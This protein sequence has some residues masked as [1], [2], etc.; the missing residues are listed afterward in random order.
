MHGER[1]ILRYRIRYDIFQMNNAYRNK[2]GSSKTRNE[3]FKGLTKD[4]AI[5][6]VYDIIAAKKTSKVE[7]ADS[8]RKGV[9]RACVFRQ[10]LL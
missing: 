3:I 6:G 1:I 10:L 2:H 4:G 8:F 5:V 9:S 7:I